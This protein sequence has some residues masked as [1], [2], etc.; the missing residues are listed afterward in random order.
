VNLN[1][2]GKE[3]SCLGCIFGSGKGGGKLS[4]HI[5]ARVGGL[6]DKAEDTNHG[7]TAMLDLLKLLVRII[8]RGVFNVEGVPCSRVS[9]TNVSKDTVGSLLLDAD[10]TVVFDPCHT[11]DNLVNGG[12]WDGGKSLEGVE[13]TVGINTA[14]LI[15]SREGSEESRPEE[16]NNGKLGDTAVGKLG[17]TEPFNITH[18]V[19]LNV[20]R[21]V[22]GGEGTSGESDG[23]ESDIS[24]KGAIKS[25]R[26]GSERKSLGSLN[27]VGVKGG[28]GLTGLSRGE[29]GG[30][31]SEEGK[32]SDL[33]DRYS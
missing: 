3:V 14:E 17:L 8:F 11:S 25:I 27:P 10:D 2:L 31:A 29:S 6:A 23:V 1:S 9:N 18:E 7:K 5:G 4:D 16:S 13:L 21:V 20:K 30:R 12:F 24:R 19:T 28:G 22:E 33:H 26:A 32:G 15:G